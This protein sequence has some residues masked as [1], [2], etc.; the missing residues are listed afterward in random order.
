MS[1]TVDK[2]VEKTE[3][4]WQGRNSD[5]SVGEAFTVRKNCRKGDRWM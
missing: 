1:A 3:A 2:E 4:A 5:A